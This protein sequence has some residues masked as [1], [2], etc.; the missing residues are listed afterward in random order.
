VHDL[1]ALFNGKIDCGG[2]SCVKGRLA[3]FYHTFH[4]DMKRFIKHG[5]IAHGLPPEVS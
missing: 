3:G 5:G 1:P 4:D 2:K